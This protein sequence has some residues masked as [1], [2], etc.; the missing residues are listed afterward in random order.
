MKS[1][2]DYLPIAGKK[3]L[4]NIYQKAHRLINKHIVHK[5]ST[6][7]GDGAAEILNNLVLLMNDIG[8][9]TGWRILLGPSDFFSVTSELY[10]LP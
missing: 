1:L 3:V 8:I 6:A 5:N 10:I 9:D 7:H 4:G 2:D